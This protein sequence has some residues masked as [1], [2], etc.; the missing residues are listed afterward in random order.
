MQYPQNQALL[1]KFWQK[2][3]CLPRV[4]AIVKAK[5]QQLIFCSSHINKNF[6]IFLKKNIFIAFR[7]L[8]TI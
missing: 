5:F 3:L 8:Y 4:F 7:L 6:F 1:G 2:T